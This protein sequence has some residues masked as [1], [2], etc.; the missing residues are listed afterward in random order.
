MILNLILG[1]VI[2]FSIFAFIILISGKTN[3]HLSEKEKQEMRNRANVFQINKLT[4]KK[5]MVT[6]YLFNPMP[7]ND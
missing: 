7:N 2:S 3:G 4:Y 1:V 6:I 5:I